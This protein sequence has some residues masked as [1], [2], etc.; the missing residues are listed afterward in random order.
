MTDLS[1]T[2]ITLMNLKYNNGRKKGRLYY[3]QGNFF[4]PMNLPTAVQGQV[5]KEIRLFCKANKVLVDSDRKHP[6][7]VSVLQLFDLKELTE[8]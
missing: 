1:T 3:Y 5:F 8:C 6:S 2:D 7:Y 4:Y